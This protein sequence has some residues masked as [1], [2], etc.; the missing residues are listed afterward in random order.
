V[1]DNKGVSQEEAV[2]R[3]KL[4][5][6]FLSSPG[7]DFFCIVA[8]LEQP[9]CKINLRSDLFFNPDG[10]GSRLARFACLCAMLDKVRALYERMK[11]Q[12]PEDE[13]GFNHWYAEANKIIE[14]MEFFEFAEEKE[15]KP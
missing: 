6:E 13:M 8:F 12:F 4:L 11:D 5:E 2:R 10:K 1:S 15:V 9:S 14:G 3:R 7:A